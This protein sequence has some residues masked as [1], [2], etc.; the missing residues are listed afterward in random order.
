M[1]ALTGYEIKLSDEAV[2]RLKALSRRLSY[3]RNETISWPALVRL[4]VQWVLD[5]EGDE[6]KVTNIKV[7]ETE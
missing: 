4:G 5:A 2:S 6:A 7:K 1:A 3:T